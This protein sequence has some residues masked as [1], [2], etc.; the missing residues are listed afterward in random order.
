ME[1]ATETRA[2]DRTQPDPGLTAVAARRLILHVA[3]NPLTGVW[4][5]MK[6]L[7]AAQAGAGA[8]VALGIFVRPDWPHR[9]ELRRLGVPAFV[10]FTPP[11]PGTVAFCFHLL[12]RGIV[13]TWLQR[14]DDK[15][16]ARRNRVVHYHNAWLS[17]AFASAALAHA[18]V[19]QVATVHGVPCASL[20]PRQPLRHAVQR[21]LAQRL[22]KTGCRLTAV[23]RDSACK[24]ESLFNLP[25]ASFTVIPNCVRPVVCA[26][27]RVVPSRSPVVGHV[28]RI[29]EG[30]GWRVTRDAVL[31][32]RSRGLDA[33]LWIAG[34]GPEQDAA[35]AW[36]AAHAQFA[37][38]LG[39]VQDPAAT[40][41]PRLD[42]IALPSLTEGMPMTLL[43]GMNAGVIPIATRVG[44]IPSVV[45][46]LENGLLIDRSPA[47]LAEGIW[48]VCN[49]EHL[50]RRL[51]AAA[52]ATIDE[53]FRPERI[54][55]AYDAVYG[56]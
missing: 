27:A 39:W 29:D 45:R 2:G 3:S 44:G 49:D 43:E 28:G 23:D 31:E 15:S 34:E 18:G 51:S 38:F 10:G 55:K 42:F 11:G 16:A 46:D 19:R 8:D 50:W 14:M 5:L 47:E 56:L 9:A 21:A 53:C 22:L 54:C 6:T 7:A 35:A 37:R 13:G 30:K 25:T 52:L 24:A 40:L 33:R 12:C 17:G 32:V 4:T 26:A 41:M 48:R 36:C 20:L 1:T